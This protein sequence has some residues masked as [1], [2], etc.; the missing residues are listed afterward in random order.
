[1]KSVKSG[2]ALLLLCTLL[3][4]ATY[5]A[6]RHRH[7]TPSTATP[8]A[9]P[10]AT[11]PT[12]ASQPPA[13]QTAPLQ[14]SIDKQLEFAPPPDLFSLDDLATPDNA[15]S[16]LFDKLAK[17]HREEDAYSLSGKVMLEEE[18]DYTLKSIEGLQLEVK[19]KTD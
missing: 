17:P 12:A 2:V 6:N 19:I 11:E 5:L 15:H 8:P 4:V 16:E 14:L 7:T 18:P 10:V 13:R 3:L 9:S 1:M